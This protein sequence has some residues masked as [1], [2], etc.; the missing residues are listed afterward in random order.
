MTS[1][2]GFAA[3]FGRAAR[4]AG[5]SSPPLPGEALD[6]WKGFI[7]HCEE[8]YSLG[9]ADYYHD[10]RVRDLLQAVIDSP[11]FQ[12]RAEAA[13]FREE[14]SALDA[15]FMAILVDPSIKDSRPT[16]WW[17]GSVPRIGGHEFAHDVAQ[18]LGVH[19]EPVET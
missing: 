11:E 14:L 19:I 18:E 5:W 16:R 7:E 8:G 4:S 9:I 6:R 1:D 12:Q 2:E 15:R 13:W 10:V 17:R 3:V